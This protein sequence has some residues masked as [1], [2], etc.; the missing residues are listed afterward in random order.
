MPG[1]IISGDRSIP[2][3][4]LAARAARAASGFRSLGVGDSDSIAVVLRN[5][6][7]FLE[8]SMGAVLAG[9]FAVPVNWHGKAE[10]VGYILKDCGAKAVVAHADLLR[11]VRDGIPEGVPVLAVPTPPEV[12]RAYGISDEAGLVPPGSMEWD[13]W[14]ERFQPWTIPPRADRTSVIYTSG[15]TGR[16]KGVRRAPAS[17]EQQSAARQLFAQTW[18]FHP[19]MRAA[20]TGP[21]YH[22]APNVYALSAVGLGATTVLQPRFDAEGLLALIEEH[23]ITHIHMVPTMFVRLLKLPAEVRRR[24]DLSSLKWIVHAAAPCP[25][26]VKQ[27]MIE[28]WGPIIHEYYGGTE[29]SLVTFARA[30]EW[31]THRGTVGRPTP[32]AVVRIYDDEGNVLPPRKVG[33]IYMRQSAVTDFTYHGMDARR[34]EVERDG[35]I[36]CGDVGYLDE[37]GYLYLSDRKIDMVISGGVN[38]YPAEVEAVLITLP[39]VHDCAVF[40]IPDPEYGERLAAFVQPMPGAELTAKMVEDHI[41]GHL[42]DFKV[43][44]LIELRSDL[45]RED[46]GKIF[47]RRLREPFWKDAG[48]S[49]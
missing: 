11:G 37:E 26:D 23:A 28:W 4:E 38:I 27:A 44:R 2:A 25:P 15:T 8:A 46:S 29:S 5:D 19:E 12:R 43:P 6:F 14:L 49:I 3:T 16:P 42:S 36:T 22:T 39:G 21:M 34:R 41:R 18:G 30:E 20:I 33:T 32:T 40:G 35:L 24:H 1:Q 13:A 45:P 7:S 48:R 10:E 17:P 9:A 47:K 31:L